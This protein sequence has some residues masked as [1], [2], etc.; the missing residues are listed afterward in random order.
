MTNCEKNN[1]LKHSAKNWKV[2]E[3][4]RSCGTMTVYLLS[5]DLAAFIITTDCIMT[6]WTGHWLYQAE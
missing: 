1:L 6:I 5:Y 4:K 2:T 3:P